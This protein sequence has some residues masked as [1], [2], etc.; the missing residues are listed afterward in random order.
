[1]REN[2]P[3]GSVGGGPQLN[4]A[5]LPLSH[6]PAEGSREMIEQAIAARVDQQNAG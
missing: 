4:A 1:M 6:R 5:S 3:S 2:R